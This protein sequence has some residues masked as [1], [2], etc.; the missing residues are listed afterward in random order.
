MTTLRLSSE[1]PTGLPVD[2]LVV[3][4]VKGADGPSLAP[5]AEAVDEAFGGRLLEALTAVGAAGGEGEVT[6]VPSMG[7]VTAPVVLAVGLGKPAEGGG[8]PHETLRRAAGS[9]ARALAG[10]RSAVTTLALAGGP[11]EETLRA[12]AE[13]FLLGAYAFRSYKQSSLPAAK[14][15]VGEVVVLLGDDG[16]A[17]ATVERAAVVAAAVHRARD[18][19]NTPPRDLPPAALAQAA[20]DLCAPLGLEVEVLDDEQLR[21]G[22]YGGLIGVGQGSSRPPRL[23]RIAYRHPAASKHVALVGKGITFDSGGLSLKPAAP[24]EWMK[25]DMAGAA[26]V[27]ATLSAVAALRPEVNVTGWAPLAEN[28]PSGTA[29]RPSDVLTIYGGKQVE[30]LNTDAEGRLVLADAIVRACEESPDYLV[31]VATLTGAQ[32]VALGTR[33]TGVMGHDAVR[34]RVVAAAVRAGESMWPMPMPEELRKG[35][36]SDVAD[37]KNTG[38]RDGGMLT[39]A[40]FLREFVADGVGWAHLDIAGPAFNQGELHGYTSKGGTGVAVRTF[41]ELVDDVAQSG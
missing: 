9:A 39:A 12:V 34:D 10:K 13:G 40:T 14:E 32:L 3:G 19:V 22:G 18:W 2:T 1:S 36:D 41:L 16:D 15:P 37:I 7:A 38:P 6:R 31:D 11:G 20:V 26:A 29:I 23:V 35:I 8:H 33:T 17:A 4:L 25:S 28:M 24:M 5:G 27:I 21:E 30:V